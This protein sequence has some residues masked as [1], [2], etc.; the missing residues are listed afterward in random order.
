MLSLRPS[1][2]S[3]GGRDTPS[4]AGDDT[5]SYAG[6]KL[7]AKPRFT[8]HDLLAWEQTLRCCLYAHGLPRDVRDRIV[9]GV[10]WRVPMGRFKTSVLQLAAFHMYAHRF[11]RCI[12]VTLFTCTPAITTKRCAC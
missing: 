2:S 3:N 9:R 5:R 6:S 4:A 1:S 12:F 8:V 7:I 10:E 11:P